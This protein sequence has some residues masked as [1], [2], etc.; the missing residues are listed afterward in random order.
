MYIVGTINF[1]VVHGTHKRHGTFKTRC[2]R[3]YVRPSNSFRIVRRTGV[4][5]VYYRTLEA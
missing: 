4:Y 3:Y 1:N 2:Y 5:T